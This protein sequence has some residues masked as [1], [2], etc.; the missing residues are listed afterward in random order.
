MA[1]VGG[2]F[3]GD[4]QRS[5]ISPCSGG[6]SKQCTPDYTYCSTG[7]SHSTSNSSLGNANETPAKYGISYTDHTCGIT[8]S[9][10]NSKPHNRGFTLQTQ[11]HTQYDSWIRQ[12][13]DTHHCRD[14]HTRR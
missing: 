13:D 10:R 3:C 12:W 5:A 7:N 9:W 11:Q 2:S 14:T 6:A 1:K 8:D 4:G